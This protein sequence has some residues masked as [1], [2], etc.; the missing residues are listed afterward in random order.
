M[1]I[2]TKSEALEV[3]TERTSS[4]TLQLH[5]TR[6]RP[7][8][9]N[10]QCFRL[11]GYNQFPIYLAIT[12]LSVIDILVSYQFFFEIAIYHKMSIFSKGHDAKN[13]LGIKDCSTGKKASE[14]P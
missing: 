1:I 8:S 14:N 4:R 13:F 6:T 5:G 7:L 12:E 3:S 10:F 2:P 11:V 9:T